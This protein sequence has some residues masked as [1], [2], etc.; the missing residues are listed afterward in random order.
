MSWAAAQLL[1]ASTSGW[2]SPQEE[3]VGP[4]LGSPQRL[5]VTNSPSPSGCW[6]PWQRH[7][8]FLS[9]GLPGFQAS[10][11]TP[12]DLVTPTYLKDTKPSSTP[13]V[14]I[15]L[16]LSPEGL[17]PHTLR[18]L[19][20]QREL[21]IQAL[22]CALQN[23]RDA[24]H[25]HIL[26]EVAGLPLER[27]SCGQEKLLQIQ[28]QKLTVELKEQKKQAQLE[29]EHLE[30]QL[31]QTST[32]LQQREAELQ[33]LHK[34]CL[35]HLARS[36]WLGR[37]LR[38]STGSVEVVTAETLMDLSDLSESDEVSSAWEGFRLEDVDWNSIAHRYPNLLTDIKLTLDHRNPG[39]W[40]PPELPPA[41]PPDDQ[42]SE[43]CTQHMERHL[44]NVE[45]SS[46]PL[47]G[48]SSLGDTSSSG[49]ADS[50][51]S[52]PQRDMRFP[53]HV[54]RHPP[55]APGHASEQTESQARSFHRGS[56]A[57]PAGLLSLDLP[58][59][60]SEGLGK[61]VLVP[62]FC[63]TPDHRQPG[64]RWSQTSSCLKIVAVSCRKRFVRILNESQE[65]TADLGGF[66]LQQLSCHFPVRMYRFPPHTLLAPRHHVTIWGEGP[67]STK[68]QPP[69]SLAQE[70]IYFH[71]NRG[72][73]TLL[74][75]PKGEVLS[76]HQA[77]HC[78]TP[79][80]KIFD[81]NT[82]L[83]IDRYPL[84]DARPGANNICEQRRASRAPPHGQDAGP[85]AAPEHQQALLPAGGASAARE[86]RDP[87]A[88]TPARGP[89]A[90]AGHH[91]PPGQ[92]GAQASGVQEE[93]EPGLPDGGAVGPEHGREQIRFPLPQLPAH[94]RGRER[95][96]VGP[97]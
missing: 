27:S 6:Y 21:E 11:G 91:R 8:A 92:E 90:P 29:K 86:R 19:W 30:K 37:M 48:T 80:S 67:D 88:E 49:G 85:V 63:A 89:P 56:Q 93:R 68:K 20:R 35:L 55:W 77:P 36:S 69:S 13:A 71:S 38:S 42:G 33:A 97:R 23:C 46:L 18:L 43:L 24:R 22:R 47:G 76:E 73:V 64:H 57:E 78:V 72:C 66:T 53:V 26:Q 45:W 5:L 9:P 3:E 96:G 75:S 79:V 83:S 31:L 16:Q 87:R 60:H 17:D 65:E 70:P 94:H 81:D 74:L 41:S 39:P 52:N 50:D 4:G 84:P 54:T 44:K 28:V 95:A 51:S 1:T 25:G 82:D 7:R 34:S 2:T 61:T 32:V 12:A 15:N 14:S 62:R 10:A 58:E 40:L 59:T